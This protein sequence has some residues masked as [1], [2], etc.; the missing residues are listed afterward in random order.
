MR[1]VRRAS[2][3]G[4]A[5]RMLSGWTRSSVVGV[6]PATGSSAGSAGAAKLSDRSTPN[7]R[8][9]HRSTSGGGRLSSAIR[10][11]A[12]LQQAALQ[13]AVAER[14]K[15]ALDHVRGL[16]ELAHQQRDGLAH[17]PDA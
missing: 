7:A 6:A 14:S 11:V 16:L 1:P 17:P 2:S 9:L 5:A 8:L 12:D 3:A 4:Q 13:E 10:G 15:I